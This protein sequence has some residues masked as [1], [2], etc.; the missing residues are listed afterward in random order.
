MCTGN[1]H[2]KLNANHTQYGFDQVGI[3]FSG[4]ASNIGFVTTRE[5]ASKASVG[6]TYSEACQKLNKYGQVKYD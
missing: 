2:E 6:K 3:T 4:I 5:W 1:E